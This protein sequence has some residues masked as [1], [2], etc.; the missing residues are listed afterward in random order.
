MSK[1]LSHAH[2]HI[3]NDFTFRVAL[4]MCQALPSPKT[5]IN[6]KGTGAALNWHSRL[7]ALYEGW[8]FATG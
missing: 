3:Q 7:T 1:Q 8:C 4:K 2:L 6:A 5:A